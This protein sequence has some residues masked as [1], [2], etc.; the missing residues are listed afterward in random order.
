MNCPRC[1]CVLSTIE[2]EGADIETCP[3]CKGEWLDGGE[4]KQIVQTVERR[5]TP[6]Q[7]A[8]LDAV[9]RAVITEDD[10]PENELT[11]PK[12]GDAELHRFIYA[13]TTG[14]ALDKCKR[15]GGI[16][17]DDAEIEKVQIL[18]EEWK[19]K[20]SEDAATYGPVLAKL[21]AES[22]AADERA[23]DMSRLPLVGGF[24]NSVLRIVVD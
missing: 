4:L 21:N 12:C 24:I 5:F 9:N 3:D 7:V 14:V 18:A 8:L 20:L 22:D 17:L 1:G 2:Y 15:C 13:A 11:C 10:S 16:W 23:A 6:E 19:K